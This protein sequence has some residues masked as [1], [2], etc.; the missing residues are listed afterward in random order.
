VPEMLQAYWRERNGVVSFAAE[1]KCRVSR[2]GGGKR[3]EGVR[4]FVRMVELK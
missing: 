1:T 4:V 3:A 2:G